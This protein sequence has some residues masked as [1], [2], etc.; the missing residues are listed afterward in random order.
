MELLYAAEEGDTDAARNLV[1]SGVSINCPD[2]AHVRARHGGT[3]HA[4]RTHT[5]ADSYRRSHSDAHMRPL[6]VA[7]PRSALVSRRSPGRRKRAT[8]TSFTC[9]STRARTEALP[10]RGGGRHS[11]ERRS[12]A[13]RRSWACCSRPAR[14]RTLPMRTA[15]NPLTWPARHAARTRRRRQP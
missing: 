6:A 11:T 14:T 12:T 3:L 10:I 13:T 2:E 7:R 15:S 1:A 4:A 5:S 8:P 9:C